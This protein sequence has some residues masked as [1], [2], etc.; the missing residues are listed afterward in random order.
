M[1]L[2]YIANIRLPTEKAH[3]IQIME[4]CAAFA[5]QGL[6]V[7]LI[8]PL[9]L[10]FMKEDPFVYHDIR[11]VFLIRK[12]PSFNPLRIPFV[13]YW[14]GVVTFALSV[15]VCA[16]FQRNAVFYTRD[17]FIALCLRLCGKKIA[18]EGHTG[19]CN[20]I[21][22]MIIRLGVPLVFITTALK[23]LH[24][25]F[26]ADAQNILVAPDGADIARFNIPITQAEARKEL[27][28][29]GATGLLIQP[30]DDAELE[31]ALIN[32]SNNPTT[33]Q[34]RAQAAQKRMSDFSAPH[35]LSQT[36]DVLRDL[37]IRC[38]NI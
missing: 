10:N 38:P 36:S 17:E 28:T 20:S 6:S 11:R 8:T 34:E 13:G 29:Q 14:I 18:W 7:E 24:L 30:G 21:V 15:S 19:Q 22:R 37:D 27:I 9:R 25:S 4:M 33:A 12:L 35:M 2:L 1:K 16:L 5:D 31:Q 26:G 3:G 23:D 32:V